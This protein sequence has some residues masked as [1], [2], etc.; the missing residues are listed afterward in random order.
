MRRA[1]ADRLPAERARTGLARVC[2]PV[3]AAV[4]ATGC[5]RGATESSANHAAWPDGLVELSDRARARFAAPTRSA[6]PALL[7]AAAA[8]ASLL[9]AGASDTAARETAVRD[10]IAG[11][12][13]ASDA[14]S[15]V[16][17]L[18]D[19]RE[20]RETAVSRLPGALLLPD[21]A[22]RAAFA[23]EHLAAR[24]SRSESSQGE[25][26]QGEASRSES[27]RSESSQ[28]EPSGGEARRPVLVY[29][30]AGWRSAEAT[31]E[32]RDAGVEAYNLEG[33][34]LAWAIAGGTLVDSQ[35]APSRRI[36]A[37]SDDF[38]ELVPST[39]EVVVDG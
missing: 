13:C 19:V 14:G 12:T 28:G 23:T 31:L 22:S 5:T 21:A 25:V 7:A 6:D 32:L 30:T 27:S 18:I 20:P 37:Y 16:P 24:A 17:I 34:I 10:T 2:I 39:H 26:S 36:H 3:V 38:A 33:G 4:F 15:L 35:G 29:C 8:E 9:A 1:R 11:E